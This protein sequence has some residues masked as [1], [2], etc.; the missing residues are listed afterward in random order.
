MGET[1][2]VRPQH[3]GLLLVD[4]TLDGLLAKMAAHVPS[5]PI[6]Q[7]KRSDL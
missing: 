7:M 6:T 3:Q 4:E 2:F 5:V 1:G